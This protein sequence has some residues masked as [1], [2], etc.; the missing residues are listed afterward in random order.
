[1]L[2]DPDKIPD[3]NSLQ[4]LAERC[5]ENQVD[6]IFTG[7]SLLN[8]R[9]VDWTVS[10]L[11]QHTH[12]PIALFPGD[13]T[14]FTEKADALLLLSLVSGRNPEYLIG[15]HVKSAVSLRKSGIEIIP[16]AYC[17]VESGTTTSVE[18]IS[19]T[20]PLPRNKPDIAC[21]TALAGELLGMQLVYLEAG[22]GAKRPV[23]IS[24]IRK[25]KECL[26]VP[27]I[28]GGGIRSAEDASNALDAGADLIVI[29]NGIEKNPSLM[30]E[31][32]SMI[33]A[34]KCLDIHQ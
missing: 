29:G 2:I 34:K 14:Q 11:K 23:P 6:Y 16:T 9:T 26:S 4:K 5:E 18:Y 21:S 17:L 15:Q 24:I 20:R 32:S 10:I 27:L 19:N 7:G 30:A 8:T 3:E 12:I 33:Q 22:S 13:C 31:V 25:V 28:V 1:M